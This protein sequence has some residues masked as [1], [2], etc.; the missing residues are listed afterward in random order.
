[1]LFV[2]TMSSA[3]SATSI[4]ELLFQFLE[5]LSLRDLISATHV[6]QDWRA[7]VPK[8]NSPL[9]LRLLGLS[10]SDAISPYPIPVGVR[11]L[12]VYN[13]E[14]K[15]KVVIPEPYRTILTEW[16]SSQPP[17]GM[18]WPH[19]VRFRAS[20]F[21]FCA[22]HRH[23]DADLCLCAEN[24]VRSAKITMP[25]DVFRAVMEEGV[26]PADQP[27][28]WELFDNPLR[29]YTGEQNAQTIRFIR[30]QPATA[31]E[32]TGAGRWAN[33]KFSVLQLSRYH[34]YTTE[35]SSDGIFVLI[36]DGPSRGQIHG[37][38]SQ[39]ISWYDGFEA[40]SFWDWNYTEWNRDAS[41]AYY[42]GDW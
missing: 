23:M 6:C 13:I 16:P 1:M 8:I 41:A 21:C 4:P 32:W 22:R 24:E 28:S 42:R 29:L 12:Y 40:E 37:W 26:V 2:A 9:R 15:H 14:T 20:G 18:Y 25:N 33:I 35:A 3:S 19:S 11:I 27:T 10:F 36:L 38:S 17:P 30:A 39:G 7:L 5:H 34:V 31:V